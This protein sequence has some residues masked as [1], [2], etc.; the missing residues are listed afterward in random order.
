[1][2][3]TST[4]FRFG[5]VGMPRS[6]PAW[7]ELARR[8]EGLGFHSLLVP[9][10]LAGTS[11]VVACT[12]AATVTTSLVVGP[13]VLA[14]PLRTPGLVAADAASLHTLT[15]GRGGGAQ[16]QPRRGR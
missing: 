6:G 11:A 1:M 12:V 14:T 16:R 7:T 2:D 4:P 13:Y 8:V 3:P 10:N 15:G 9:D 5:L